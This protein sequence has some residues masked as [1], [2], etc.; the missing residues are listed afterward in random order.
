MTVWT[1][2]YRLV[3]KVILTV[4]PALRALDLEVK[5]LFLLAEL[6]DYPHPAT[7]SDA[8][9]I[10][11]AS[12]TMYVKRLEKIGYIKREIDP[13]DL[14]RHKLTMTSEGRKALHKGLAMLGHAFGTRMNLLSAAQQNE[15]R[16]MLEKML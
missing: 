15:L 12:V 7:L 16:W 3:T 13:E 4:A 1:L 11:K 8:L 9:L 14:R 5:E 6:D 2:Q 10:P